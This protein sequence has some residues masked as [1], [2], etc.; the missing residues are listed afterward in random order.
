M[1]TSSPV[2]AAKTTAATNSMTALLDELRSVTDAVGRADLSVRL[3]AASQRIT[4]NR[5]RVVVTGESRKGISSL[6]NALVAADVCPTA[7]GRGN[8]ARGPV[9][10]EYGE[11]S[12]RR[13]AGDLD[14]TELVTLP[15]PLLAEGL[16]IIDTPGV[17][18][19]GSRRAAAT[20]ELLTTAD[21]VLF[22]S[23]A[24]QE[25]TAPEIRFL[26]QVHQLCPLVV[27]VLNKIDSYVRWDDIQKANRKHLTAVGLSLPILPV[28]SAM[29]ATAH[30][31]SDEVLEVESGIPQL[32]TFLRGHLIERADTVV[33][34]SFANDVRAISDHVALAMNTELTTLH[35]PARGA[36][37]IE[38]IHAAR[39]TFDGL[40]KR[41]ANWQYVLGD[42]ITELTVAVD[43]DLRTRLRALIRESEEEIAKSDPV[44]QWEAFGKSLDERIA[45]EV[46]ANFLLAHK[47]SIEL[48]D[49]VAERFA[50]DGPAQLPSLPGSGTGALAEQW[51]TLETLESNKA[52]VIQRT[53]TSLRGSY[54][55][56]L[57]VGVAT[58]LI[59]LALVNPY[60]IAAGVL[61]GANTF[62]EDHKSL[63]ARRR[64]EAKLAVAKLMDEVVFQVNNESKQRLRELQRTLR[65][66]FTEVA[67]EMLRS[68]EEALRAAQD[69][70]TLHDSG[71][72]QRIAELD[73]MS[74]RL[75]ELR[76]RAATLA[77]GPVQAQ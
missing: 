37:L 10:V 6:V 7:A 77:S 19:G 63:K 39:D 9:V 52:G 61:L 67:D 5:L 29:H 20:L 14:H 30:R 49:K 22:V 23:D 44:K 38:R 12:S 69:A 58:S 18:G 73:A 26:E 65:D 54:G 68:A 31:L 72:A 64:A 36:E 47:L 24:S 32:E 56:V 43:H 74:N 11:S 45:T 57:M 51:G 16:V 70:G 50:A 59:G 41:T 42:G 4:D 3:R 2:L 48:T 46:S 13:P 35:D 76:V 62:R 17:T 66:H 15:A 25:Y 33:R 1:T 75:R 21:A 53:I 34:E 55:G 27:C 60:S 8:P 40:R 28:S 71:R